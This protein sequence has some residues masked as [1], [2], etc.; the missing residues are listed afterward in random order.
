MS[1]TGNKLL[2]GQE[3]VSYEIHDIGSNMETEPM[4]IEKLLPKDMEIR[5]HALMTGIQFPWYW[6]AENIV[7]EKPDEDLFQLTHMFYLD[8]KEP[9]SHWKSVSMIVNYFVRKT[10]IQV[11][12]IVRVKGNLITNTP[13]KSESIENLIHLDVEREWPGN[14]VSFVYYVMDSD[15]DTV[16][17]ADDK[18]TIVETSPPIRGNCVWFDSKTWHRSSVPANHKRRVVINVILEVQ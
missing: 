9:S 1:P 18:K 12:R 2:F 11:K 3:M 8:Q 10:N 5:L 4:V 15:G 7:A 13:H 17:Y 14:Y 16:I 6:N